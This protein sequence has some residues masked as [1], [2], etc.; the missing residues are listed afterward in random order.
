MIN[1]IMQVKSR[2]KNEIDV[3]EEELSETNHNRADYVS[4]VKIEP[5]GIDIEEKTMQS[6]SN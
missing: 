5:D 2:Q 3:K 6:L 4:E 1:Q